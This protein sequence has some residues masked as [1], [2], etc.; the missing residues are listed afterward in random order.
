MSKIKS[1]THYASKD[2]TI[3]SL[4]EQPLW[5]SNVTTVETPVN[6][7]IRF[8]VGD[9]DILKLCENGDIYVNGNLAENDKE[10]VDAL[11]IFIQG[12]YII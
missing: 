1:T 9:K 11:R 5:V 6:N 12:Q 3:S 7:D 10:V 2:R 8:V 4:S